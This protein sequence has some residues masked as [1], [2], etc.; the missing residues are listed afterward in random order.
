[1]DNFKSFAND[2]AIV[3]DSFDLVWCGAGNDVKIFR[4]FTHQEIPH[5][6]AHK[7]CLVAK[8]VQ[9]IDDFDSIF[10]NVCTAYGVG[11][12]VVSLSLG[13]HQKGID[14]VGFLSEKRSEKFKHI[15]FVHFP[16]KKGL[17]K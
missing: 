11:L 12:S 9:T 4:S 10:I 14:R 17:G 16:L 1:M 7:V 5:A 3:K 15:R 8:L 2:S 6:P 13:I